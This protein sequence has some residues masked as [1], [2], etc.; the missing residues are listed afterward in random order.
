MADMVDFTAFP[1]TKLIIIIIIIIILINSSDFYWK[2]IQ[3]CDRP[4]P[5]RLSGLSGS[6]NIIDRRDPDGCQ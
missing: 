5:L 1:H 6:V 2:I 4:L 3:N